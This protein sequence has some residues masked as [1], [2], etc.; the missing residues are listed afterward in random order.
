MKNLGKGLLVVLIG[1]GIVATLDLINFFPEGANSKDFDATDEKEQELPSKDKI[2]IIKAAFDIDPDKFNFK[3]KGNWITAYIELPIKY[4][5]NAIVFNHILLNGLISP[6]VSHY[7]IGD[8]DNNN[9]PDLM[10]KFDRSAVKSYL[11]V[12]E[13]CELTIT[14]KLVDGNKFEGTTVIELLHF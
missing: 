5:V 3:S 13:S 9:I 8:N 7:K 4:D 14:G 1:F 6:E 11:E 2:K 12:A 10:V